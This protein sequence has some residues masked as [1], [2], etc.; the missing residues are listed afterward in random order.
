MSTR[1]ANDWKTHKVVLHK[2]ASFY[3]PTEPNAEKKIQRSFLH[4]L[5][6]VIYSFYSYYFWYS[7]NTRRRIQR[8]VPPDWFQANGIRQR[9]G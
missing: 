7:F 3:K 4:I 1:G 8:L 9:S 2:I 6:I 5:K